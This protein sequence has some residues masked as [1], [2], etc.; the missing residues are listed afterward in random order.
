MTSMR[1]IWLVKEARAQKHFEKFDLILKYIMYGQL[2]KIIFR[3]CCP[4][5]AVSTFAHQYLSPNT[6]QEHSS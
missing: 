6:N 1:E 2:C 5:I 4:K 3:P